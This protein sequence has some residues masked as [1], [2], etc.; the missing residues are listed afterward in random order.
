MKKIIKIAAPFTLM[1]ILAGCAATPNAAPYAPTA[2]DKASSCS[3]LSTRVQNLNAIN[4]QAGKVNA[5]AQALQAAAL[6]GSVTGQATPGSQYSKY[7]PLAQ[8]LANQTIATN[9]SQKTGLIAVM[10][11]KGCPQIQSR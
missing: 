10:K 7:M 6:L 3:Q 1:A 5:G 11:A 2:A 4:L 9:N 8:T